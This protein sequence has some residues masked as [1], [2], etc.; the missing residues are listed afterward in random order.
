MMTRTI[1]NWKRT[2]QSTVQ[3]APMGIMSDISRRNIP[4]NRKTGFSGR[5][6]AVNRVL[7]KLRA[8]NMPLANNNE[9]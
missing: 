8:E 1:K 9:H 5:F 3:S 7:I 6:P 4:G 2:E